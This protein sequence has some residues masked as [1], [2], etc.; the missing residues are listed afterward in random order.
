MRPDGERGA[1]GLSD[2]THVYNRLIHMGEEG[3]LVP[4][5]A[6]FLSGCSMACSFCSEV[7]H[8]M[9]PFASPSTDPV[10]LARKVARDLAKSPVKVRNINFVGGEPG[11]S[12]PFLAK[13]VV[14][15]DAIV[16]ERPPILLNSNGYLTPEALVLATHLCEIFVMDM[17]FGNDRCAQSIANTDEYTSVL[18]R[19]LAWLHSPKEAPEI[20]GVPFLPQKLWIRHL[21]MPG[22]L[23]CCTRPALAWLAEHTP[24]ARINL[25]PAFHDFG[26]KD[27]ARWSALSRE[28][29]EAGRELLRGHNLRRPYFDGRRLKG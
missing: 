27:N 22:H 5:Y 14:A 8:L 15:L 13:F 3:P 7:T 26:H 18:Q 28:E 10:S 2:T 17:K 12:M 21:L 23:E 20:D 6:I 4:S 19:N 1:C 24:N 29:K 16:D 25:M 9:P 11:I